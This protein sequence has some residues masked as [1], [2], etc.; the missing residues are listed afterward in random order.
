MM[1]K[2]SMRI[3]VVCVLLLSAAV[4][5]SAQAS[6]SVAE[7]AN[8]AMLKHNWRRF[9]HDLSFRGFPPNP[10]NPFDVA[11]PHIPD[12]VTEY[13]YNVTVRNTSAKAIKIIGWDYVFV[14][15]TNGMELGRHHFQNEIR[16]RPNKQSA[17]EGYTP[18][19]PSKI[20]TVS[21]LQ[22]NAKNPFAERVEITCITYKDGSVW[23]ASGSDDTACQPQRRRVR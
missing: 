6:Q 1:L 20:V 12:I 21:A 13:V 4:V 17:L 16:I 2:Y 3:L 7:Q 10:D 14:D 15:P 18:A 8:I 11:R 9:R 23:R 19:P 22:H 5:A